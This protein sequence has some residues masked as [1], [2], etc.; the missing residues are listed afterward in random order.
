MAKEN[1]TTHTKAQLITSQ[2]YAGKQDILNVL[3]RDDKKYSTDEVDKLIEK[4]MKG[5]VD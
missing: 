4:F 5:K 2:K 1:K 3:L